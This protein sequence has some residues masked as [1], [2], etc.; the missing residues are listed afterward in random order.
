METLSPEIRT[1][2]LQEAEAERLLERYGRN[3]FGAGSGRAGWRIIVDVLREPMFV[4]L[5]LSCLL[6]YILG[7]SGQGMLM[8]VAMVFVAAISW[9]QEVKSTHALT[10]LKAYTQP[11]VM[12]IRDGRERLIASGELVPGDVMRIEEGDLI[13]ADAVLVEANDLSVNESILT[14]ESAPVEKMSAGDVRLFQGTTVN[15]GR[16]L[17]KVTATGNATELGKLGKSVMAVGAAKTL[18]QKQIARLVKVMAAIGGVIF[19]SIWF[20]NYRHTGEMLQS[21]L[22]ALTL[23]MAIIPEE[24]PVAFSSFMAL[25][26]YRMAGLGIIT[27]Q[28]VTIENLGRVSVICLDKTGTITENRMKV[29]S[30]YDYE[31]TEGD[32]AVLYYARLASERSPFDAMEKAIVEAYERSLAYPE[33]PQVIVHEYPLSGRPPMM[34]HVYEGDRDRIVTGKGAPERIVAV[35]GLDAE[36][37]QRV[38]AVVAG[39]ASRGYRV[40]GICMAHH[41]GGDYPD[42]Q[43]QFEWKFKGL[44]ALYDPPKSDVREEFENWRRA[45]IKIKLVTGDFRETAVE[46]A[47]EAGLPDA[48]QVMTGQEVMEAPE[49]S[50]WRQVQGCPVFVRMFPEAKL[51]LVEALEANGETVAMIGDGVNDGPALKAAHIG[52]AMGKKGTEIARQAADLVLTDDK[53]ERVTEAIRQGRK[54][55]YN[56]KKA[57]RYIFSIHIPILLVAILPV[58]LNWAYPNIFSPIHII[59]FEL[60]MGPTC[61]VFY[62]NEPVEAGMMARPPRPHAEALFSW[63]EIGFNFV[64]GGVIATGILILYHSLMSHGY[65]LSYVRSIVF[66]TLMTA[67]LFLTFTNRSFEENLWRTLRYPNKLAPYVTAVSV[68]FLIS[69]MAVPVLREVF[70]LVA[71]RPQ[72][73]LLCVVTAM[74]VTLWF[75]GYKSI[76][77]KT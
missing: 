1:R 59:F 44:V 14:G 67:N 28:P 19:I 38:M 9:Y 58:V 37:R 36:A 26:A 34:T 4:L 52:I 12:V 2:G 53:L 65:S 45:G 43:D 57:I 63:K 8:L 40:L 47:R 77:K 23:A 62:E 48:G 49:A 25:G 69:V 50:L 56:L 30:V 24:I 46:I 76:I 73:Y 31:G 42:E 15:S 41:D 70:G 51:R 13:P 6:Y 22:F 16:C 35:C 27:R 33:P 68:L 11:G 61:S 10:A 20:L 32:G 71:L 29:V 60:I 72:H 54:I 74:V 75:E 5:L 18:L 7:E 55:Y 21:L 17:A 64:Q 39:M 3:E 66:L